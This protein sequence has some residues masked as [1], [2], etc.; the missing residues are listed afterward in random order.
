M[1]AVLDRAGLQQIIV[2]VLECQPTSVIWDTDPEPMVSDQDRYIVKLDLFSMTG[3]GWDEKRREFEPDG[4]PPNSYVTFL[5]GNRTLIITVRVEAFDAGVD[6]AEIINQIRIGLFAD[7]VIDQLNAV[8]LA[9]ADSTQSTRVKYSVDTRVVNTA[10]AD[11]T[12]LGVALKV[13]SVEIDSGWIDTV[14]GDDIVPGELT[15]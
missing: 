5:V 15:T 3:D 9:F 10:V 2:G 14:N 11:F 7:S 8:S 1:T 4:Y 12:F 13:A 6:A